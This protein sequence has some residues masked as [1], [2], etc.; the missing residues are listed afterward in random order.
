[1]TASSA[2]VTIKRRRRAIGNGMSRITLGRSPSISTKVRDVGRSLPYFRG[3]VI[4]SH[5]M[6]HVM[7]IMIIVRL[8]RLAFYKEKGKLTL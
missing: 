5:M 1:M 4:S 7:I 6:M 3:S 2:F 8:T